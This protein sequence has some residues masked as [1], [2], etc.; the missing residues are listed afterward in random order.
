MY[1]LLMIFL[2]LLSL[3]F[4]VALFTISWF[5]YNRAIHP[6]ERLQFPNRNYLF[7]LRFYFH[8]VL[9]YF[10]RVMF[11][12]IYIKP[13][14]FE[15][16]TSKYPVLLIHGIFAHSSSWIRVQ[17]ALLKSGHSSYTYSYSSLTASLDIVLNELEQAILKLEKQYP[18]QKPL[19]IAHSFGGLLMRRWL[20]DCDNSKRIL[21]L[22]TVGTPHHGSLNAAFGPGKLIKNIAPSSPLF[23]Y[24]DLSSTKQYFCSCVS[25]F[26][27]TDE[28]VLPSSSLF[29]PIGWET[30]IVNHFSHVGLI[31]SKS[32]VE[33]LLRVKHTYFK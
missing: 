9:G 30:C 15:C 14:V 20:S 12:L 5:L 23:A 26:S 25:V 22:M 10:F 16:Q 13:R 21:G 33:M 4:I 2:F 3:P 1:S 24:L 11:R 18:N 27:T 28:M 8:V 17:Y 29:P 7:Y 19:V 6:E 31:V 32:G